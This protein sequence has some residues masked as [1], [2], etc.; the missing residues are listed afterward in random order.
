MVSAMGVP[1]QDYLAKRRNRCVGTILGNAERASWWRKLTPAE[2]EEH[3][4]LVRDS[5]GSFFDSVLDLVHA[6]E[7]V[8]RNEEVIATLH[9]VESHLVQSRRGRVPSVPLQTDV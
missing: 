3:R 5:V 1:V 7:G 4:Q 9:R 8:M 6:E 2:Q